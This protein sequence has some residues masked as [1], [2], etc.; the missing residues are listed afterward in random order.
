MT[1]NGN[2]NG[3]GKPAVSFSTQLVRR[4]ARGSYLGVEYF[5]AYSFTSILKCTSFRSLCSRCYLDCWR[6]R[7]HG[8]SICLPAVGHHKGSNAVV[9]VWTFA[10]RKYFILYFPSI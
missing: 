5:M 8:R 3:N 7:W 1:K 10:W 2:G 6:D 4:F 9:A